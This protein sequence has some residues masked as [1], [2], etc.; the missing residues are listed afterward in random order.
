MKLNA[1]RQALSEQIA[2]REQVE[3]LLQEARAT[4]QALETKLAHERIATEETVRR[5]GDE[6]QVVAR[7]LEEER[8]ARQQAEQERDQAVAIRQEAEERLREVMAV[9]EA[10]KPST[11]PLRAGSAGAPDRRSDRISLE[12]PDTVPANDSGTVKQARRR[13]RPPK[14]RQPVS[15]VVEWCKAGWRDRFR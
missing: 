13:G 5:L 4:I 12:A 14:V 6:R 7:L 11:A 10:Q 3:Q 8:G 2:A 15:E 9:Q 1:A